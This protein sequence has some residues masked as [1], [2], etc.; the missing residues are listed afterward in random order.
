ML[1]VLPLCRY[2]LST[3]GPFKIQNELFAREVT[4]VV[5]KMGKVSTKI[6]FLAY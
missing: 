4:S 6:S 2:I 5:G 1:A 3:T